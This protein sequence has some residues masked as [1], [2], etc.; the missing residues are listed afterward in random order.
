VKQRI[1]KLASFTLITAF[2]AIGLAACGSA[3]QTDSHASHD[4]ASTSVSSEQADDMSRFFAASEADLS[5]EHPI[6]ID[7]ENKQVKVYGTVNGK[8]LVEPTR[9]GFNWVEGKY[10][11][12]AVF[13][14][15]ANPLAFYE[16]LIAIGGTPAVEKGGDASKEFED[17]PDGKVIKGDALN[18]SITWDGAGKDYDI[19]DVMVDSTGKTLEYHFGGNYDAAKKMMTGC[20]MCFDS[21][22][23]GITSNAN[24]P[25]DTFQ[26]G[27]AQFHGNADVL[28]EDGTPVYLTY[29]FA[30]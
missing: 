3:P 4:A 17:T 9:H 29:S 22:P 18:V 26:D 5:Q 11:D 2:A 15:Y 23:V 6:Y 14:S 16:A 1:V 8:Y 25:K 12:Q 7:K 27:K 28:P 13:K 30:K 19:N 21:C 24:Q 20:F 10:G